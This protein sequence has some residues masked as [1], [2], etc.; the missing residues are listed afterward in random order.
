M[1]IYIYIYIYICIHHMHMQ[2]YGLPDLLVSKNLALLASILKLYLDYYV[3]F[4]FII[5]ELLVVLP[6]LLIPLII[7]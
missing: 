7:C 3:F 5:T 6:K 1:K 4:I 2:V